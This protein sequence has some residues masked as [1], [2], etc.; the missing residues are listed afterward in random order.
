MSDTLINFGLDGET[1]SLS[2]VQEVPCGGSFPRQFSMN[3]AGTLLAVG[4]QNDGRVVLIERDAQ[5][6]EIGDF[7]ANA[8]VEGQVTAVIF[9]E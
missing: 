4:L 3:K 9:N 7:V 6:G 1:G 5:T 2:V 8:D